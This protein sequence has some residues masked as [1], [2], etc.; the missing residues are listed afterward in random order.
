M[1]KHK[2]G[3][4]GCT[5]LAEYSLFEDSHGNHVADVC[6]KCVALVVSCGGVTG[7]RIE[8]GIGEHWEIAE[9]LGWVNP[10]DTLFDKYGVDCWED[11]PEHEQAGYPDA[12][13]ESEG[14]AI[15]YIE[16]HF[17]DYVKQKGA[18]K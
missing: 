14:D 15:A 7:S 10:I 13:D 12:V 8:R 17:S 16:K 4:D 2:C 3:T 11:L 5:N 9:A 1:L 6:A 18:R